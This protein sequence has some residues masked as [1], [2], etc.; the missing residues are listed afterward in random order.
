MTTNIDLKV[1]TRTIANI[2]ARVELEDG[3]RLAARSM[4]RG[5]RL[6]VQKPGQ[7][8][9]SEITIPDQAFDALGEIFAAVRE[10]R[11]ENAA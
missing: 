7:Y 5:I 9:P 1:T 11:E 6:T 2:R 3:T 4:S 8:H 10:A